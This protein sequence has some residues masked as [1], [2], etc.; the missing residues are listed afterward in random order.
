[1]LI[2][3]QQSNRNDF[4][5][6]N[7]TDLVESNRNDLAESNLRQCMIDRDEGDDVI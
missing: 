5:E 1:M 2:D 6:S 7:R 4:A 3:E